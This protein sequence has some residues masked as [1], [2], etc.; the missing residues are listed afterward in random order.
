MMQ[1]LVKGIAVYREIIHKSFK[2]FSTMSEKRL[3]MQ[4]WNIAGALHKPKG[5]RLYATVPNKQV[6]FLILESN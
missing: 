4:C 2:K 6:K 1:A 3:S 5:I